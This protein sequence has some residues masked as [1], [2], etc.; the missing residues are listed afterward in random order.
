MTKTIIYTEIIKTS[1]VVCCQ[2]CYC[3]RRECFVVHHLI[4]LKNSFRSY[5]VAHWREEDKSDFEW[6]VYT[7]APTKVS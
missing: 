1:N 3:M 6:K 5:L 4:K 7:D 2:C